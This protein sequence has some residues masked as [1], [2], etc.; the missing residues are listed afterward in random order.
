[1]LGT[2]LDSIGGGP[3]A[4]AVVQ[5]VSTDS[6][7]RSFGT[8]SDSAGRFRI[9]G[10]PPGSYRIGF[11]SPALDALHLP[12]PE[13]LL[14]LGSDSLTEV[15]LATPS[16][17]TIQARLCAGPPADSSGLL[18]GSVREAGSDVPLPGAAVVLSW[19]EL[20]IGPGVIRQERRRLPARTDDEGRF[21]LCGVPGD[22]GVSARAELGARAS[23]YVEIAM[24]AR[25]VLHEDFTIPEDSGAIAVADTGAPAPAGA[26]PL[27]RGTA[28]LA[29]TV[30][31]PDGH[32]L[33]GATVLVWGSSAS[34]ITGA[35]GRFALAALPAGTQTLEARY[36]GF[37]PERVAVDLASGRTVSVAVVMREKV[38]TLGAVTVYG[39][40]HYRQRDGIAGFLARRRRGIGRF[41]THEEIARSPAFELTDVLASIPMVRV[42]PTNDFRYAITLPGHFTSRCSPVIWVDGMRY[43][44]DFDINTYARPRD[45]AAVEVYSGPA[46]VPAR[47]GPTNCG[48]IVIWTGAVDTR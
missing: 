7:P 48:A 31:T 12:A 16:P 18:F 20:V 28:R 37:V 43:E 5:L 39:K 44:S 11:F 34:G 47:F 45:I 17:V 27:F 15:N 33:A 24:P 4:G 10:V 2:V 25:G 35:D 19:S 1:M 9:A 13:R 46:E 3:L 22:A 38:T 8:L 41:V 30:R 21:A 40:R 42:T 32:P 6:A 26:E 14:R 23:G 36:I 29:G